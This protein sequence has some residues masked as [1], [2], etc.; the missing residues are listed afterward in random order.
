M[1]SW[2]WMF[3]CIRIPKRPSDY[4]ISFRPAEPSG[5]VGVDGHFIVVR[6]NRFWNVPNAVVDSSN[7]RMRLLSTKELENRLEYIVEQTKETAP[8]VGNLTASDRDSWADDYILLASISEK[9]QGVLH[10]IHSAAFVLCVD[11]VSPEPSKAPSKGLNGNGTTESTASGSNPV[12]FSRWLWHGGPPGETNQLG[13][14]QVLGRRMMV[15][16]N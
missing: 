9:N 12:S 11:D 5:E 6:K 16:S 4:A 13:N 15:I 3:D 8:A 14:R 7:G 2:R 1:D 10:D